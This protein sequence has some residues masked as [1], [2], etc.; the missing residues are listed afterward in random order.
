MTSVDYETEVIQEPGQGPQGPRGIDGNT[1][2]YGSRGPVGSDGVI[3]NFWINT[4]TNY[5]F[6]PKTINGWPTG[7]SIVGPQGFTGMQGPAGADGN[8]ILYGTGVPSDQLGK[9]GNFYIDTA[10][11]YFYGPKGADTWPAG[12]SLVGPPS[13]RTLGTAARAPT[14][15]DGIDGDFWINTAAWLIYGPKAAGAWPAGVSIVGP[16][17]PQGPAGAAATDWTNVANKPTTLAGYG[18]TDALLKPGVSANLTVGYTF[19]AYSQNPSG[20]LTVNPALGNYQRINN[21]GAITIYPPTVECAVDILVWNSP[22]AGAISFGGSWYISPGNTGDLLDAVSGH[23]FIISV[24]KIT[25]VATYM[26]KALV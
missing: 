23:L 12:F 24:R 22:S 15:S 3:G 13:G 14:G 19:S 2:L 7:V 16:Q 1:I 26:I 11:H 10:A 8:T 25:D 6:G 9:T 17:G 5:I 4:A 20:A 18:I 21:Y